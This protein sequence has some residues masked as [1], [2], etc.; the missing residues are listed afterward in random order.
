VLAGRTLSWSSEAEFAFGIVRQLFE[1]LLVNA[2]AVGAIA[3]FQSARVLDAQR[4]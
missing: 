4:P 3:S 1:P 2:A